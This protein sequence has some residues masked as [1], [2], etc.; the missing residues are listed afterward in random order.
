MMYVVLYS[1]VQYA[2]FPEPTQ[3]VQNKLALLFTL[4]F[5]SVPMYNAVTQ[6]TLQL[7]SLYLLHSKCHPEP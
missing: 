5:N 6:G 2:I 3:G 4:L 7:G 1:L